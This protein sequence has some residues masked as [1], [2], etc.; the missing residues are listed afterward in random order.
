M[1]LLLCA[2]VQYNILT[3]CC[4]CNT[5]SNNVVRRV[6]RILSVLSTFLLGARVR[7]PVVG[8]TRRGRVITTLRCGYGPGSG[9]RRASAGPRLLRVGQPTE[10]RAGAL[11]P[12]LGVASRV[13]GLGVGDLGVG[14]NSNRTL[15]KIAPRQVCWGRR[16]SLP[17]GF[18]LEK[19]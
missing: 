16:N 5:V 4:A 6:L 19:H 7:S 2:Y 9:P 13:G 10:P 12:L 18:L 1:L 17:A 8:G 14:G 3:F 11:L 15:R